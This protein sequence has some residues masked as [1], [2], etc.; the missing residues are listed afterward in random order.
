L[1]DRGKEDYQIII[2]V[3]EHSVFHDP[4]LEWGEKPRL[5]RVLEES[6]QNVHC[7]H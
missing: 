5:I 4:R 1:E 2:R 7:E 3:E 6:V